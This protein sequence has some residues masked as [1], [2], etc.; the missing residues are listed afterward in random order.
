[1][2]NVF[3]SRQAYPMAP[4]CRNALQRGIWN[5]G[6]IAVHASR[7]AHRVSRIGLCASAAAA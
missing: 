3:T 6:G 4:L 7:F 5:D 1:M 2:R